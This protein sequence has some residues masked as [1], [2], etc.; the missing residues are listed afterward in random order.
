MINNKP[1]STSHNNNN[2][3]HQ[4]KDKNDVKGDPM[5]TRLKLRNERLIDSNHIEKNGGPKAKISKLDKNNK[6]DNNSI[7][8]NDNLI[9]IYDGDVDESERNNSINNNYYS[10][11]LNWTINDVCDYLRTNDLNDSR[12]IQLLNE[13]VCLHH[14]PI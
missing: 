3:Q 12:I 14:S 1:K 9:E 2:K 10:N 6:N 8:T 4:Q 13:N 5:K 7:N 11:P